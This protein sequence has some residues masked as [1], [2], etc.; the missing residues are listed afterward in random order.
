MPSEDENHSIQGGPTR[1][2]GPNRRQI[3]D[4]LID[5]SP[6]S[7]TCTTRAR[8][9]RYA[10]LKDCEVFLPGTSWSIKNCTK[11]KNI[12]SHAAVPCLV[13]ARISIECTI[14]YHHLAV[15][16]VVDRKGKL[17]FSFEQKRTYKL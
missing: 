10:P 11:T 9:H 13:M 8:H 2:G 1:N 4:D 17:T 7:P 5:T 16:G 6:L 12:G 3:N 14:F 15:I